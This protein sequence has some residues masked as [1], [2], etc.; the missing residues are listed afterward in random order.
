VRLGD[1]CGVLYVC[2]RC[3]WYVGP[4]DVLGE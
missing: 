1:C 3:R 2:D 4:E